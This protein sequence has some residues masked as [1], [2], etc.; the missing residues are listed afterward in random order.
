MTTK[1]RTTQQPVQ[2]TL[3]NGEVLILRP[4]DE[5]VVIRMTA[6]V[7]DLIKRG[8]LQAVKSKPTP[9]PASDAPIAT[10][11]KEMEGVAEI[12]VNHEQ[13]LIQKEDDSIE[14]LDLSDRNKAS[15]IDND[16]KTVKQLLD[17][18]V[19]DIAAL[20]G[21]TKTHAGKVAKVARDYLTK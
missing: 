9:T 21:V 16:V 14:R 15:L 8:V 12:E 3:L 7:V 1:Y 11:T 5:P 18:S 2:V 4:K 10:E 17:L 13:S 6:Q 20:C 19:E